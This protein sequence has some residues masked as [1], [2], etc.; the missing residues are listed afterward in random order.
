V[1]A[2]VGTGFEVRNF[3]LAITGLCG[4]CRREETP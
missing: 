2:E 1:P 4:S 3:S